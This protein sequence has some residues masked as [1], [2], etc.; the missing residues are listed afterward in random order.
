MSATATT[1]H[2][3][4]ESPF[5]DREPIRGFAVGQLSMHCRRTSF[6]NIGCFFVIPIPCGRICMDDSKSGIITVEMMMKLM[7]MRRRTLH[8]KSEKIPSGD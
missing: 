2:R 7:V 6:K 4:K 3:R 5:R 8:P 1:P